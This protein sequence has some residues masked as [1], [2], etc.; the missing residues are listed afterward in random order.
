MKNKLRTLILLA[1]FGLS[2]LLSTAFGQ[3][4]YFKSVSVYTPQA[5]INGK[6]YG[7]PGNT[8]HFK[9]YRTDNG[10][11]W[12]E[13][14]VSKS[15][16]YRQHPGVAYYQNRIYVL[17]GLGADGNALSDIWS[18]GDGGKNWKKEADITEIKKRAGA[19]LIAFKDTLYSIGGNILEGVK[20]N[21]NSINVGKFTRTYST[22]K[23][24]NP[25]KWKKIS[26][27]LPFEINWEVTKMW[28]NNDTIFVLSD[29]AGSNELEKPKRIWFSTDVVTWTCKGTVPFHSSCYGLRLYNGH[30]YKIGGIDSKLNTTARSYNFVEFDKSSADVSFIDS[31]NNWQTDSTEISPGAQHAYIFD[32]SLYACSWDGYLFKL[33]VSKWEKQYD[34]KRSTDSYPWE[35]YGSIIEVSSGGNSKYS[36]RSGGIIKKDSSLKNTSIY[37]NPAIDKFT[38][39]SNFEKGHAQLIDMQGRVVK[40]FEVQNGSNTVYRDGLVS[41]MYYVR[42][43]GDTIKL[44]FIN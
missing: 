30:L 21:T 7:K 36:K 35:Q 5:Y 24:E 23:S 14:K 12:L 6:P 17:G 28:V 13:V 2:S 18:S 8:Y 22:F 20:Q 32:N 10:R 42:Y 43:Q 4:Y 41:G 27:T 34:K 31:Y 25:N 15:P 37:P 11:D 19:T 38:I 26:N 29:T 39:D 33:N 40:T 9:V 16:G 3:T 44:F 1:F